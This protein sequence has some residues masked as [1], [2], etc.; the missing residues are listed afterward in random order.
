MP[1]QPSTRP[2]YSILHDLLLAGQE[3]SHANREHPLIWMRFDVPTMHH[4]FELGTISLSHEVLVATVCAA[5]VIDVRTYRV[6]NW[7]TLGAVA[8]G[9]LLNTIWPTPGVNGWWAAVGVLAGFACTLPFYVLHVMGAGDVKLMAA[10][11]AFLGVP[12]VF[13]AVLYS[14]IAGGVAAIA[15]ALWRRSFRRMTTN[16]ASIAQGLLFA[17]LTGTRASADLPQGQSTG[18][19]PYGL[20]ICAGTLAWV[21]LPYLH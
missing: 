21:F 7:L 6:P 8:G 1:A 13:G 11:G 9:I 17:A 20:A 14:F 10:I 15:F 16:V 3:P 5:A 18:K 12:D 2:P 4:M 19:L